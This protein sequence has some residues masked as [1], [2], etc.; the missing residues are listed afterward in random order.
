MRAGRRQ[1]LIACA[2]AMATS[3]LWA[4]MPVRSRRVG[5]LFGSTKQAVESEMAIFVARLE[6]L[7]HVAGKT[8]E[9]K[10]RFADG[11]PARFPALA[12]ELIQEDVE[13][14]FV[15]NT[16]GAVALQ[17]LS[18]KVAIIF[19]ASDP[20]AAGLIETLAHPGRNATGF[21]QGARSIAAKRVQLV[22]ETFPTVRKLGVIF[23]PAFAVQPELD[24]INEAAG[25]LAI[26][27]LS[28]KAS[29]V[30]DYA[31]AVAQLGAAGVDSYYVVYTGSSFANR[32]EIAAMIN[33][34]RLPAVYG[35]IP[36]VD[37]GGLMAYAWQTL[38]V[39]MLAAEYADRILRGAS[40]GQLPVQEPTVIEMA[41]NRT[42]AGLQ[43]LRIPQLTLLRA[44]RLVD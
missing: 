41:I 37:S 2:T 26:A 1:F 7:G 30:S 27:V 32:S 39:S 6:E 44:D 29:S 24:V 8:I 25:K 35:A 12:R 19:N 33:R 17:R 15:P 36:F 9:L 11:L 34:T 28:A 5:M 3:Q 22:K 4:Q 10:V 38:R 16:Q 42:T 20:I 43:R 13:V 14:V 18:P 23:D 21:T 40:A 31:E